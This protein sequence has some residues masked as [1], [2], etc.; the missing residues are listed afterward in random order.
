LFR[1]GTKTVSTLPGSF[2]NYDI[3]FRRARAAGTEPAIPRLASLLAD[4]AFA[5]L[6]QWLRQ[7]GIDPAELQAAI[8]QF[9]DQARQAAQQ[10]PQRD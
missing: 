1:V 10:T 3:D 4:P 7:R 6:E 9:L 8:D 2:G 5:T